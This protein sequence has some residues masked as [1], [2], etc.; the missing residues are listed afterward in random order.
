MKVPKKSCREDGHVIQRK[1]DVLELAHGH[2]LQAVGDVC[3]HAGRR[4]ER[5]D[6]IA[7]G[8]G[9]LEI[10]GEEMHCVLPGAHDRD[11]PA[12]LLEADAGG[13]A[14]QAS[15]DDDGIESHTPSTC[16]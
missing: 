7:D 14:R 2:Q 1:R 5:G 11:F 4:E 6:A 12:R 10:A 16:L 15:T 9:V 8:S 3:P 13:E